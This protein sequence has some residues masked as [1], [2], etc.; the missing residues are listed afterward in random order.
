MAMALTITACKP[1]PDDHSAFSALPAD[2]W[3]YGDTVAFELSKAAAPHSG[4][5]A[6][7]VR[8]ADSYAYGNLW[9]EVSYPRRALLRTDSVAIEADT[10]VRD[11]V[12]VA[13]ADDYGRW[14]GRSSGVSHIVTDT[15]AARYQYT[16]TMAR[17]YVRHIMRCDRLPDIEQIGLIFIP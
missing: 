17:I 16:D 7:V 5:M 2:G 11:T 13:L 3:A 6:I 12:N 1:D 10:L 8:H 4:G 9:L 15:L 14:L